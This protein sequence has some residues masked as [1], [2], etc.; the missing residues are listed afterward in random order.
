LSAVSCA[1]AGPTNSASERVLA[2]AGTQRALLRI[3]IIVPLKVCR[4]RPDA[5]KMYYLK[6]KSEIDFSIYKIPYL[7]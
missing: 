2:N 6:K 7:Q 3:A 5:A 4:P 1:N